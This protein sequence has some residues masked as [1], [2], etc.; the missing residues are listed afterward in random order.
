M[1]TSTTTNQNTDFYRWITT[2]SGK[3]RRKKLESVDKQEW[4]KKEKV[5]WVDG[6]K[7][8]QSQ[9]WKRGVGVK[10]LGKATSTQKRAVDCV[11]N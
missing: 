7:D 3:N 5:C 6:R 8:K 9:G 4:R 11:G 2:T 10:V 1:T